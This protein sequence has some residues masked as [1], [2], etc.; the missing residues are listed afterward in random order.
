MKWS[1]VAPEGDRRFLL[2]IGRKLVLG[3][4]TTCDLPVLDVGVSR[5]HAEVCANPKG[6]EVRD[7]GSRNG[8]YING[9][10]ITD[11]VAG[12]GDRVTFGGVELVL[13]TAVDPDKPVSENSPRFDGSSTQVHERAMPSPAEAVD[14]VA[15]RRLAALVGIAQRL[16]RLGDLDVLLERIVDDLFE[17]FPADRVAVLM[18]NSDGELDTRVARDRRGT[19]I[20]GPVP[21]A[22]ALGVAERQVALLTHDARIDTRTAGESVAMQSVRSALAAP[23]LGDERVA[24]GVVYVDN[25]R[26]ANAFTDADLDFLVAYAGIAAAAVE[27]E[28]SAERLRDATRV[29]ENFERYFTPQLAEHIANAPGELVLGG[30]RQRVTVLFSDIRGFTQIA[31]TLPPDKMADQLNEYFAAMVECIF[32]HNGALDKFIGDEIMAYWGAPVASEDAADRAVMSALDMQENLRVLN[33]RWSA[34]GRPTLHAGI[35]IN[36]GD[37]FVG[38]IGSPRRLEY[39]LIG[40]TVNIANRLCSLANGG[41]VLVS[42][43]VRAE[44]RRTFFLRARPELVPHRHQGP[45]V[46]VFSMVFANEADTVEMLLTTRPRTGPHDTGD[47]EGV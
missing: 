39:T 15:G 36:V 29:R 20:G 24:L 1:L 26:D 40:D 21:R 46:A 22:I 17:A 18:R 10:R 42:E 30:V 2:P 34:A 38:N 19:K 8:T 33:A 13:T 43:A 23:L 47:H 14:A 7:L 31:E 9:K 28:Q 4:D 6:L 35:G 5:R 11:A 16:G 32:R 41:E 44:L 12:P 27:R 37:A 45:A 3:R 25:L